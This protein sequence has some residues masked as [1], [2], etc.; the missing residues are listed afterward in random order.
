MRTL[1][2]MLVQFTS[3]ET[4]VGS[5]RLCLEKLPLAMILE[6]ILVFWTPPQL[7]THRRR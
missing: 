4:V 5:S 6:D 3:T 2:N 1:K 7:H